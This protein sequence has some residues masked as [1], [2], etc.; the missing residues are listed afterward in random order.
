MVKRTLAVASVVSALAAACSSSS[1]S[2]TT[3]PGG[4][5]AGSCKVYTVCSIESTAQVG[6]ALGATFGAGT[7]A[8][9]NPT[10]SDSEA[11][12]VACNYAGANNYSVSVSVR[13]CPCGDN[14]PSTVEA[15]AKM[16][17]VVSDVSGVGDS[18]FWQSPITDAGG[19]VLD[20]YSL[21]VFV[22]ADF[23][24]IVTVNNP[25]AGVDPLAGAKQIATTVL[26]GL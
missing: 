4:T 12:L 16:F 1:G 19:I 23:Y 14:E 13:C 3:P 11:E 9:T 20:Y 6:T 21:N 17:S 25:P 5:G 26:A 2:G 18:A 8:D 22:G 24:V 7:E 15:E 10:P